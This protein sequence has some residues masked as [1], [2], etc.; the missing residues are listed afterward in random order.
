MTDVDVEDGAGPGLL[1]HASG[2]DGD[3]H[4]LADLTAHPGKVVPLGRLGG[5]IDPR[6][7]PRCAS[8]RR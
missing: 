5:Q 8:R 7:R 6:Q 3:E 2:D 4:L 1:Q